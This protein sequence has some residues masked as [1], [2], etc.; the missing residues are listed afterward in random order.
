MLG[1]R[2]VTDVR[3]QCRQY[4]S[5][6]IRHS[7]SQGA[8]GGGC[9]CLSCCRGAGCHGSRRARCKWSGSTRGVGNGGSSSCTQ[10]SSAA[11]TRCSAPPQVPTLLKERQGQSLCEHVSHLQP[12]TRHCCLSVKIGCVILPERLQLSADDPSVS[13]V[14]MIIR[15]WLQ[16]GVTGAGGGA[17]GCADAACGP[18]I[19]GARC[20]RCPGK[21]SRHTFCL[22]SI[23]C[24]EHDCHDVH[25][26]LHGSW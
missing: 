25:R 3:C 2:T 8:A 4:T 1:A 23:R 21:V 17:R 20:S 18:Q 12:C 26:L 10:P 7:C 16:S 13:C 5:A 14:P 19:G 15:H 22:S 6:K 9:C 24:N 11:G